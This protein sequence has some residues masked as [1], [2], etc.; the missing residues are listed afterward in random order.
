[1]VQ[2]KNNLSDKEKEQVINLIK[3]G[4][5]GPKELLYKMAR[6]EKD[7]FL[8]WNGRNEEVINAVLPFHSIEYVDEHCETFEAYTCAV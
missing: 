1:M 7:V 3:E 5:V 4:K 6:D 8:F 2:D